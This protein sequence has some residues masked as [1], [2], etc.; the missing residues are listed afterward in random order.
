LTDGRTPATIVATRQKYVVLTISE[1]QGDEGDRLTE[2]FGVQRVGQW[3][4]APS[5]NPVND[6]PELNG[7]RRNKFRSVVEPV[8]GRYPVRLVKHKRSALADKWR[9]HHV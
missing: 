3:L 8:D 1:T 4:E 6:T 2:P 7:E 5:P 9:W